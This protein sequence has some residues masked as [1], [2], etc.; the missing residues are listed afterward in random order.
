MTS[1]EGHSSS[2]LKASR[3]A[4]TRA[5]QPPQTNKLR[6]TPAKKV[7]A[8]K[9]CGLKKDLLLSKAPAKKRP[10]AKNS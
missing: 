1:I 9:A 8:K 6:K 10:A 5:T 7:R 2:L 4:K 3:L